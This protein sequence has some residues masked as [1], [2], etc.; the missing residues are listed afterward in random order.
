MKPDHILT[1]KPKDGGEAFQLFC[2]KTQ[3]TAEVHGE[4]LFIPKKTLQLSGSIGGGVILG[5]I[6]ILIIKRIR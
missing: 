3:P 5:L 4:G 2:Y 6:A 1:A